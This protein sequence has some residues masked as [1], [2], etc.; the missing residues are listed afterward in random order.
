MSA[1]PTP[2]SWLDRLPGLAMLVVLA[3]GAASVL[4]GAP[5]WALE[6]GVALLDGTLAAAI[7][8]T[9]DEHLLHREASIAGW[10]VAELLVFGDGNDGVLVGEHG[11]L[12]T[13]EEFALQ[14]HEQ[15]ELEAKLAWI[16]AARDSLRAQGTELLVAIIPA[17]A[18]IHPEH[19]GRHRWPDYAQVRY[20]RFREGLEARGIH[21]PD[22]AS[23]L[24]A[25]AAR[26][27]QIFLRT[28]TH[29]TPRG[30]QRVAALLA[31]AQPIADLGQDSYRTIEGQPEP[32][33]GDLLR[34]LPLGWLQDS[35]GPKPDMLVRHH[36]E[37]V[38]G[39][40]GGLGLF[41]EVTIP[42]TLVG[43]SY[44]AGAGWNF[45]GALQRAMGADV[46]NAAQEGFGPLKPMADYLQDESFLQS[47]PRLVVWEIPERFVAVEYDLEPPSA[48]A[49]QD[50]P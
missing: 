26:G 44:S 13:D 50:G 33:S 2:T 31:Q 19:L 1:P 24:R 36:T 47:P 27:E 4:G 23:P 10:A 17:K 22:L 15:G 28:D 40:G 45:A 39:G 41:D 42:V 48:A 29:W 3:G 18:R 46:L 38:G 6:P 30:A 8:D 5:S 7:E 16:Q 34:F 20:D 32:H 49:A 43:T 9:A 11:W 14:P 25:A 21:A 35:L 12:Y 37:A